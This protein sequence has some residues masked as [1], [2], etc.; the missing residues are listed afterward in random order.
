MT[1]YCKRVEAGISEDPRLDYC[2]AQ[3][4]SLMIIMYNFIWNQTLWCQVLILKFVFPIRFSCLTDTELD[5][6]VEAIKIDMPDVGQ[7]M[8]QGLLRSQGISV[9]QR[10]LK[11]IDPINVGLRWRPRIQLKP[12][13]VPGPNSLWHVGT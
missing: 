11:R 5:Q 6:R 10:S 12:Y 8:V 7:R 13:S 3:T 9:P 2:I 1:L 4:Q